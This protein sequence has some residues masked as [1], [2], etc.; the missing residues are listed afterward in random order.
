MR[1]VTPTLHEGAHLVILAA[2]QP[3]YDALVASV[4]DQGLTLTEWVPSAEELQ[5]LFCGGHL[6]LWTQT[7]NAP[8]QP[9]SLEVVEPEAVVDES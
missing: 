6:Y 5:R 2:T 3:E 9:V 8:F 4:D 7:F 1:S